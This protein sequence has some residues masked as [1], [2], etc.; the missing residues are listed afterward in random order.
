MTRMT[1]TLDPNLLEQAREALGVST[2]SAAIRIALVEVVRKKQLTEA[3]DHR[4]QIA[5]EIDQ[6]AL[7][8][9]RAGG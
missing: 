9:L 4:G 7:Q 8:R 6:E 2:N 5:L 1:V 3:L